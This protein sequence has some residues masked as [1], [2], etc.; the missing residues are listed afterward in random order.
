MIIPPLIIGDSAFPFQPWLLKPYTNAVLT[1]KQ[2]YF[3][4]SLR[5]S[6]MSRLESLSPSLSSCSL[7]DDCCKV[8]GVAGRGDVLRNIKIP[9]S[10]HFTVTH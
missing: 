5:L 9:L 6:S 4:Y 8:E 10:A 3:N 7:L 2:R 1:E